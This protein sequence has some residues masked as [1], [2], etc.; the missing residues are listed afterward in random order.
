MGG[1]ESHL[2]ELLESNK[3]LERSVREMTR[4]D[5]EHDKQIVSEFG[6]LSHTLGDVGGMLGDLDVSLGLLTSAVETGFAE[7]AHWLRLQTEELRA[8]SAILRSPRETEAAELKARGLTAYEKRLY[9]EAFADFV[10]AGSIN[11]Y[12]YETHFLAGSI[13]L[14]RLGAVD[15]A[16]QEFDLAAKYAATVSDVDTV[17]SLLALSRACERLGDLASA[18]EAAEQARGIA[19][20]SIVTRYAV[21]RYA[22]VSGQHSEAILGLTTLFI[23]SPT[24]A[25]FARSD[26]LLVSD[27]AGDVIPIA[28]QSAKAVIV[29]GLQPLAELRDEVASVKD[30]LG[31]WD[32]RARWSKWNAPFAKTATALRI[33]DS[34]AE[35]DDLV[36]LNLLA[37]G[38][39]ELVGSLRND[40]A[41]AIHSEVVSAQSRLDDAKRS[42]TNPLE[43]YAVIGAAILA[44]GLGAFL[45]IGAWGALQAGLLWRIAVGLLTFAVVSVTM[46]TLGVLLTLRLVGDLGRHESESERVNREHD[47][48]LVKELT[49]MKKQMWNEN[50][51]AGYAL[52]YT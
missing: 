1:S 47:E 22:A 38:C 10:E 18:S 46:T 36:S 24:M 16:V 13:A 6:A 28:T 41:S 9:S 26:S 34:A 3:A 45:G 23:E 27:E 25:A 8:I 4:L 49:A 42:R 2:R 7:Q 15:T 11:P 29:Q 31:S 44:T 21:A 35:F 43:L 14:A 51:A 32:E 50:T 48:K 52:K 20:T 5:I 39:G 40:F 17:L 12:D 19:P 33:W 37:R 30:V